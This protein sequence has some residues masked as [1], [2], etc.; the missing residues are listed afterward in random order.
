MPPRGSR[1][2][3]SAWPS[4]A[5]SRSSTWRCLARFHRATS[6]DLAAHY[7]HLLLSRISRFPALQRLSLSSPRVDLADLLHSCPCLRVLRVADGFLDSNIAIKSESW[8][9]LA[10]ESLNKWTDC[11]YIEAPMLKKLA[12]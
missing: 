3:S 5:T 11:I 6:M 10:A 2:R 8:E 7:L 12:V 9:E 4:R 1:R